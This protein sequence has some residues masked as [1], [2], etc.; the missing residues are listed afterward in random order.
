MTRESR[1]SPSVASVSETHV[2]RE[3]RIIGLLADEVGELANHG[4]LLVTIQGPGVGEH[5]RHGA[6]AL[7]VF[8]PLAEAD[9]TEGAAQE[10]SSRWPARW[11][12]SW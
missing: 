1:Q 3:R 9:V 4:K 6:R 8:S 10:G 7:D 12:N 2:R 5:L 11:P